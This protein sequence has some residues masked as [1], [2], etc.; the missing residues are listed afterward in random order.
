MLHPCLLFFDTSISAFATTATAIHSL[1]APPPPPPPPPTL[2]V[3]VVLLF[4]AGQTLRMMSDAWLVIWVKGGSSQSGVD[5]FIFIG[6]LGLAILLQVSRVTALM[7]VATASG[8]NMHKQLF[9]RVIRA[10]ISTFFDV[11]PTGE[12]INR[13]CQTARFPMHHSLRFL[14]L[15][16]SSNHS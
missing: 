6:L 1:H 2:S 16:L 8:K 4:G 7:T 3:Q 14:S 12:I 9:R 10:P 13:L 15:P 5:G 11:T